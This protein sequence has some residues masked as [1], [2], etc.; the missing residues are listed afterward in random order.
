MKLTL[1]SET[2]DIAVADDASSDANVF[3][4]EKQLGKLVA[5]WPMAKLVE[6]WNS[7]A[8]VTPFDDLKPVKKFTD[9][10]AAV[11]RI[12]RAAQRLGRICQPLTD[13]SSEPSIQI[14]GM[15]AAPTPDVAPATEGGPTTAPEP[16]KSHVARTS[17]NGGQLTKREGSKKAVVIEM[18]RRV[19]G[20]S[21]QEIMTATGWQA[22]SVRGMI[23][24]T[25]VKKLHMNVES[26][27]GDAG[28]GYRII[29]DVQK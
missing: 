12:W 21:L 28:R 26:F 20:A 23:S 9:R 24:G 22:H 3:A 19:G 17:A 10:A 1:H 5:D 11:W 6:L 14:L 25:I 15:Q 7:F 2:L 18:L 16:E 27:E 4:T 29:S 8:G 13:N